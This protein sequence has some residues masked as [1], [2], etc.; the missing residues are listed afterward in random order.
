MNF[1]SQFNF[2]QKDRSTSSI[3]YSNDSQIGGSNQNKNE[4]ISNNDLQ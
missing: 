2:L 1:N 4:F 3:E